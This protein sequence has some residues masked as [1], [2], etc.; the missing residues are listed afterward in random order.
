VPDD[1]LKRHNSKEYIYEVQAMDGLLN[2]IRFGFLLSD[3]SGNTGRLEKVKE[4][5]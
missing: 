3:S 2:R 5:N 1:F 4:K